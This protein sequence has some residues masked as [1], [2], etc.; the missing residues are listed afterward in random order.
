MTV[1]QTPFRDLYGDIVQKYR[2]EKEEAEKMKQEEKR[3]TGH[4]K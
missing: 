3:G 1:E 2:E 4:V